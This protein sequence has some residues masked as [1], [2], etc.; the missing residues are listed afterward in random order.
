MT[1]DTEPRYRLVDS[2]GNVVGSLYAQGDGTLAIQEGTS[3]SDNEITVKTDGT[4]N[5]PAV[6]TVDET[7]T[8][9]VSHPQKTKEISSGTINVSDAMHVEVDG[10]GQADDTLE[11]IN[12]GS[13][14]QRLV[15]RGSGQAVTV[16]HGVGNIV[17]S[18]STDKTLDSTAD[19]LTLLYDAGSGNW[20]QLAFSSP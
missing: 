11:T 16:S 6:S 20:S 17:L 10:E 14:G 5:A 9:K 15:L 1:S 3:G 7:I 4:F 8:G 18:G 19:I 2:N 13:D 12:G